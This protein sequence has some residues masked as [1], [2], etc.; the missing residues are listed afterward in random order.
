MNGKAFPMFED[1]Q[2]L[3]GHDRATGE[4]A[5]DAP[6]I[7]DGT[8]IETPDLDDTWNDCYSPRYASGEPLFPNGIFVDVTGSDPIG[9]PSTPR[10]NDNPSTPMANIL[11]PKKGPKKQTKLDTLNEMMKSFTAQN[12]AHMKKLTNVVGYEN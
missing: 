11:V 9:N 2:T 12:N 7:T 10:G 8:T 3:F 5:E 4:M 6:E 1:W